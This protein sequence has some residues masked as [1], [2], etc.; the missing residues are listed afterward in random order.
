MTEGLDEYRAD[1]QRILDEKVNWSV[2]KPH[3]KGLV[4]MVIVNSFHRGKSVDE[5]A[6]KLLRSI[7]KYGKKDK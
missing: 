5:T 1:I 7:N 3:A 4:D 6:T 2:L